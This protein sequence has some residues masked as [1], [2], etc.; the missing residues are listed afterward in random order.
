MGAFISLIIA[1]AAITPISAS[2]IDSGEK[3][4]VYRNMVFRGSPYSA[5]V[6]RYPVS[7][8]AIGYGQHF[9]FYRDTQG[10]TKR[11][12]RW[13][14]KAITSGGYDRF[15]A[16]AGTAILKFE[17]N[18]DKLI[19]RYFNENNEPVLNSWGVAIEEFSL[20]E[21]GFRKSLIYKDIDGNRIEDSRGVWITTWDVSDD[22]KTVIEER[23]G[24]D[25]T[26]KR[27]NQFLDF[28]KVKMVFNDKGLRVAAWNIDEN[29]KPANSQ[30]RQVAGVKIK[31]DV[32]TL[33]EKTIS[34]VDEDGKPK[35]LSPYDV[36]PGVFGFSSETYEHDMNGYTTGLIQFD[37]NGSIVTLEN[38]PVFARTIFDY[39]GFPTDQRYFNAQGQP[40]LNQDGIARIEIIRDETGRPIQLRNYNLK[41]ELENTRNGGF[42]RF[43]LVYKPD[44]EIPERTF[45]DKTGKVISLQ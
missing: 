33:D 39:Y 43:E 23:T 42:A 15:G 18:D 1:T 21:R 32:S 45:F 17:Y 27:Y 16:L 4:E 24:K 3:E 37:T 11:I 29:G 35:N 7:E 44:T 8:E 9:R 25:G 40:A 36:R 19:R 28:E 30:Y 6:G 34:W 38:A 12:E 26:P 14:R 5:L 2:S 41:G 22:G 20:D 31:W 13:L 10:R